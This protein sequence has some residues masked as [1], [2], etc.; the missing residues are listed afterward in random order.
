MLKVEF[1]FNMENLQNFE[2]LYG[3]AALEQKLGSDL[4]AEIVKKGP[5]I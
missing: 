3:K 2:A 5:L 1:V 4:L